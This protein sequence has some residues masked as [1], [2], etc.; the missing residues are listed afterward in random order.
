MAEKE[1]PTLLKTAILPKNVVSTKIQ[2]YSFIPGIL[3]RHLGKEPLRSQS[4]P[5]DRFLANGFIQ[6]FQNPSK[7]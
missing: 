7:I 2:R 1:D 6:D 4:I 3:A 5:R